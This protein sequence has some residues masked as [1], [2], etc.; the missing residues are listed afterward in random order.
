MCIMNKVNK[1]NSNLICNNNIRIKVKN[2][3]CNL[4][5]SCFALSALS[6]FREFR[7]SF[8]FSLFDH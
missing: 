8:V 1:L 5:T 7:E 4:Q 3:K 2:V 6:H